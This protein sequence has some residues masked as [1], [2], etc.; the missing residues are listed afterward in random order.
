MGFAARKPD[1]VDSEE[2][3]LISR[4]LDRRAAVRDQ[5][6]LEREAQLAQKRDERCIGGKSIHPKR[7]FDDQAQEE[8]EDDSFL[9]SAS[10]TSGSGALAI[11]MQQLQGISETM[12]DLKTRTENLERRS[13]PT[14]DSGREQP[15]PRTE[16]EGTRPEVCGRTASQ[17]SPVSSNAAPIQSTRRTRATRRQV[18]GNEKKICSETAERTQEAA[19]T[20][21]V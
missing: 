11:I 8:E 3:E 13:G 5:R 10:T 7:M 15:L 17:E 12:L 16:T 4:E 2:E 14:E 18:R 19:T 21:G 1:D 20:E 9:D 6:R